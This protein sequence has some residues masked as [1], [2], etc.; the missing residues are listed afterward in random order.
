MRNT[1]YP[2]MDTMA[3]LLAKQHGRGKVLPLQSLILRNSSL[4]ITRHTFSDICSAPQYTNDLT[5]HIVDPIVA[6]SMLLPV[7][8]TTQLLGLH[9]SSQHSESKPGHVS[10]F[11]LN[12]QSNVITRDYRH[13]RTITGSYRNGKDT[14]TKPCGL[15]TPYKN[16][17][18]FD[19]DDI[20]RG[21]PAIWPAN[22]PMARKVGRSN[23][24]STRPSDAYKLES[25]SCVSIK[26]MNLTFPSSHFDQRRLTIL[27]K[28]KANVYDQI[29]Y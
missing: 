9:K 25:P 16:S 8:K 15:S 12:T 10:I 6:S 17:D 22:D 18:N 14:F 11:N 26:Q 21:P 7:T 4:S 23:T 13:H 28:R 3:N 24:M 19:D 29:L 1:F 5:K 27:P 20:L 2:C